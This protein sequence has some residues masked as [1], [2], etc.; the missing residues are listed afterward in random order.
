MAQKIT[1]LADRRRRHEAGL[2][3]AVADQVGD[4]RRIVHVGLASRHGLDVVRVGDD[5]GEMPFE[6]GVHRLPADAGALHADMAH[7][8]LREPVAQGLE[9]GGHGA[10]AADLLPRLLT[11]PA[12]QDTGDDAGLMDVEA[13]RAFN[14]HVHGAALVW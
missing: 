13:G 3:Q 8:P 5:Q 9:I 12:D 14:E 2:D 4:P 6:D 7:P 1:Q 11:R 10:E